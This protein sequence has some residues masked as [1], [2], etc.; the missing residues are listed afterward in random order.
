MKKL[1]LIIII[2]CLALSIPLGYF[3]LRSY[4]SLYQED[5]AQLRYFAETLF[6]E[7]EQELAIMVRQEENRAV[8]EYNYFYTP[9]GEQTQTRSPLSNKPEQSYI[10]GY[11]QNNPD[12]SFQTPLIKKYIPVPKDINELVKLLSSANDNFNQKRSTSHEIFEAQPIASIKKNKQKKSESFADRFLNFSRSKEQKVSLGQTKKRVEKITESQAMNVAKQDK[13]DAPGKKFQRN[14]AKATPANE[15][16]KSWE[17]KNSQDSRLA[18][19]EE[20]IQQEMS[21]PAKPSLQEASLQ[22]SAKQL[23]A[24]LDPMQ[25]VFINKDQVY[26][27]RRIVIDNKI[28]RQ[29]FVLNPKKFLEYLVQNHF[30][31]QPMAR[32]THI[33]LSIINRGVI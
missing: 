30:I 28:F 2:F 8:D 21:A 11:F 6:D 17:S 25:S 23:E 31:K 18:G 1:R 22:K 20:Y 9:P 3:V 29:G 19:D 15:Y 4:Q 26:I 14:M 12:G 10:I 27:F 7:M 33:K 13:K 5:M 24:E 32:F 16:E